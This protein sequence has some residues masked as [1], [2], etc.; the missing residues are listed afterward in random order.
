MKL[1][2]LFFVGSLGVSYASGTYAQTAM[3]SVESQNATVGEILQD[4]ENQSEYDFFYNNKQIDLNRRVSV[5]SHNCDIFD[6]L[7]Q[8]FKGTNVT[9]SVLDKNIILSAKDVNRQNTLISQ[10]RFTV[11]GQVVD[12]NGEPIIGATILEMGTTNGS[13]TDFDGNFTLNVSENA[14]LEVS[15][16]G[17]R[18]QEVIAKTG[19]LLKITL[20]EDTE[21]LEEVVVTAL[22][23]KRKSK[24][25]GYN[26]TE[27]KSDEITAVK[28]ANFVKSLAGKVAG[29]QINSSAAGVG[30]STKV[31]LRGA[32]SITKDN[33]VL[34][35]I[36]G[37]PIFNSNSG[38]VQGMFDRPGGESISDF[39]P[40]D[41][42]SMS[43]LNGPSAA[44]LYGSNAANGAILITTK[45]GAAGKA[46]ITFTH[47][48]DFMKPFVTPKFQNTYGNLPGEYTSWGAKLEQPSDFDP[49]DFFRTG[50]NVSNSFSL[51]TGTEKN[52]TFLSL[53]T[54]NA[55]GI[56]P[57]N[58]YNRYNFT[59]RNTSKLFNDKVTLDLGASYVKQN[60]KNM[61]T[62]GQYF[63]PLIPLYLF[64]R[65]EDFDK[66]RT[67]ERYDETRNIYTQYWPY[68]DGGTSMQ[69]PYWII[70][71]NLFL[72]DK[73][74][75]MFNAGVTWNVVDWFN[76]SARA[77]LDND[78]KVSQKKY[79][80]GTSG[81]FAQE[82]GYYHYGETTNMQAYAD[83]MGNVNKSFGDFD[84]TAHVGASL[85]HLKHSEM[86]YYGHLKQIPNFFAVKNVDLNASASGVR[87]QRYTD[88]TQS[89]FAS[90]D[91]GYKSMA[92]LS[93][94]ARNDWASALANTEQLSFFYPSVGGSVIL[95]EIFKMPKW[96][97]FLKL[98]GSYS[99]VGSAIPRF[100]SIPTYPYDNQGILGTIT[101]YP[102]GKLYPEKTRSYELGV[103]FR[104]FENRLNL[105]VTYYKSNTYN[106]TFTAPISAS[107]G[108]S[109]IIVQTGNVRNWGIEASLSYSDTFGKD[110]SWDSQL[111]FSM[112]RNKIVSLV[113]G[114][115]DPITGLPLNM[116]EMEFS[117]TGTYLMKLVP[118]GS[119]G[120]IYATSRL[121]T[122]NQGDIWV[123]P[124]NG[125]LGAPVDET[126][127]VGNANPDYN[128]GFRNAFSW[129]GINLSFL[130]TA[131]IGGEVVSA[132]QAALDNYGVSEASAIAR[133]N[134]GVQVNNGKLDAQYFYQF[135]GGGETGMIS[136]YVYSATNVRLQELTLGYTLPRKWF[137]D[138]LGLTV[139]FIGRNLWMIYN[140]AP[141]D[142]E[143]TS[144]T[145]TYY[146]GFDYFMQPSTRNLGFSVKFDY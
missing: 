51:S 146:Q 110:F 70:N 141:F 106:Q 103:N 29:L 28:D 113:D 109:S 121:R 11:K 4:I 64:P 32:K 60:D 27:V 112:N 18:K 94:T 78:V 104:T 123:N 92:Y 134:G 114:F 35:V 88:V 73:D 59:I 33:N 42:E 72:G 122:D 24:A 74:R 140:K 87:H 23:I 127:K 65:G 108:Y 1:S 26:L 84:L 68:G 129:K 50:Y 46:K 101:Q 80:A 61:G 77:R 119:I 53:G 22:G 57:G 125:T 82:K 47:A 130:L 44:A 75:Y 40:E 115:D 56:M 111:T 116:P 7:S 120:D 9:F 105:D 89:I 20:T 12:A 131:R 138:K 90:A 99:D 117:K 2:V 118:G 38:S 85:S 55:E 83:V 63:N 8:M 98:R 76:I 107:T 17:Y 5:S 39:N 36:D 144:S 34:Y 124:A 15:Y 19:A 13:V 139:S 132:T 91:L 41:I 67:Y 62:Q 49:L 52:Q 30:G 71:R 126:F 37:V 97:T 79:Y 100:L 3:V 86:A 143:L 14:K 48:T 93:V 66:I 31:V 45:K 95:S 133:D 6:V 58:T 10:K 128:L 81:K 54:T 145:G 43:V 96:I 102:V 142:P 136:Q 137:N 25:L 135:I 69:N 21:V 16:I